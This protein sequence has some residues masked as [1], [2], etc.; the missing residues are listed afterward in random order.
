MPLTPPD[1]INF[2]P[3]KK[4][5]MDLQAHNAVDAYAQQATPLEMQVG[6]EGPD[7]APSYGSMVDEIRKLKL[8]AQESKYRSIG[9]KNLFSQYFIDKHWN[10]TLRAVNTEVGY[11]RL[12]NPRYNRVAHGGMDTWTVSTLPDGW[13][14]EGTATV[15]Q[16]DPR[17][18]AWSDHSSARIVTAGATGGISQE[19][20]IA[21]G[22]I[23]TLAFW[24]YLTTGTANLTV[25]SDGATPISQV[26]SFTPARYGANGWLALP[27]PGAAMTY[28]FQMP[29]DATVFEVK[30]TGA[31]NSDFRVTD[32]QCGLGPMRDPDLYMPN[33]ADYETAAG[34]PTDA[35]YLVK[36][37]N[38]G[39]SAE[40][41]VTDTSSVTV[42]WS[43]AG[44]AKFNAQIYVPG[45]TTASSVTLAPPGVISGWTALNTPAGVDNTDGSIYMSRTG[46]G[47]YSIGGYYKTAPATPWT[48]T[49]NIRYNSSLQASNSALLF[50]RDNAGQLATFAVVYSGG[51]NLQSYKWTDATTPSADYSTALFDPGGSI[52]LRIADNGVNRIV[53]YSIDGTNFTAFHTVGRTDF[54]TATQYGFG[55]QADTASATIT[56]Q[57]GYGLLA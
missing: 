51:W 29:D 28:S 56:A 18:G 25:T 6:D 39:L 15:S 9:M 23:H 44:Q 16:V 14:A 12:S 2:L 50:F 30:F 49:M 13:T 48:W 1:P 20:A 43:T 42:D 4:F 41:V 22:K 33:P 19:F 35:D 38:A 17:T 31:T 8:Q 10:P 40:R 37:A 27:W 7:N 47:A 5:N 46:A 3:F 54:L 32:V 45:R 55:L 24:L 36:T 53:S 57:F 11:N 26:F 34:A 21:P 52:W